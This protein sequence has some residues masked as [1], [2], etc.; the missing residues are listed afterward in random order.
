MAFRFFL[1]GG[2][3]LVTFWRLEADAP[4]EPASGVEAFRTRE[5][6][7]SPTSVESETTCSNTWRPWSAEIGT[8]G[9]A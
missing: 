6:G 3:V 9:R 8:A 2:P 4:L 5:A 7:G 1:R